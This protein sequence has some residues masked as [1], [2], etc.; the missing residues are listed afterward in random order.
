MLST[1]H[2]VNDLSPHLCLT[3]SACA[4][5]ACLPCWSEACRYCRT[6][7]CWPPQPSDS[8]AS[9][10][11]PHSYNINSHYDTCQPGLGARGARLSSLGRLVLSDL[12]C[13]SYA[14]NVLCEVQQRQIGAGSSA[15]SICTAMQSIG[16]RLPHRLSS[17][18]S[19][20]RKS[21]KTV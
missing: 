10:A 13:H 17:S 8:S 11:T 4:W 20:A 9:P 21:N 16:Q 7:G 6:Q 15:A 2:C 3:G 12:T 18:I 5:L 1:R 14:S 19:S